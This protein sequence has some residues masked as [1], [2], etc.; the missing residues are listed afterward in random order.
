MARAERTVVK[1]VTNAVLYSDGTIRIDNVR[2]SYPHLDVP[3]AGKDGDDEDGKDPKKKK[4][5][6]GVT[7]MLPKKSHAAAIK[8]V[9]RAIDDLLKEN[10]AK[11]AKNKLFLR[12]GDDEEAVEYDDHFIVSARESKRPTCRDRRGNTLEVEDI[13]G[14]FYGGCWGNIFIRPWYQDGVKVGKGYGK[15]VNAGLI[16]CQFVRDDE[17]FG[18]GRINDDGVFDEVDNDDFD[19]NDDD[20]DL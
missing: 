5:K 18:E 8:L 4:A 7:A 9:E 20:D 17:P 11:V 13:E 12:D 3:F 2:L 1:K 14:T 10:D 19:N 16:A 15:R 6:Y